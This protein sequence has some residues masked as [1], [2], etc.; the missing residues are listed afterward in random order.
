MNSPRRLIALVRPY[1]PL[2]I[3]AVFLMAVV[4]A[5]E[6]VYALL[7]R[8]IFDQVLKTGYSAAP[9][10]LFRLP[11]HGRAIYLQD[12]LPGHIRDPLTAIVIA[13]V[14]I[15]F[16]KGICAYLGT[17]SV[18]FIGQSVVLNLRNR[19]YNKILRQSVAFFAGNSTGQLMST[20]MNDIERI[21]DAVSH[22]TANFLK[23]SFTLVFL[24]AFI[25]YVDWRLALASLVV[26][27]F[28]VLPSARIGRY[29]RKHSRRSQDRM[30]DLTNILQ[31][32]L[33]GIRVVQAFGMERFEHGKFMAATRRLLKINLR[34]IRAHAL[35]Q[36]LM[37]LL[38]AI[39]IAGSLLYA[40]NEIVHHAQTTGSFVAF[41]Y[42]LIKMYEPI[43]RLTGVNNSFQ[44]AVGASE[45]AFEVL[46]VESEVVQKPNAA[47]LPLFKREIEFDN[48]EFSYSDIPILQG[49]NLKI[50]KGEVVAIVGSSGAGKTT[51]ANLIPRFFDVT[52]GRILFDG[53]DL[54]DVDLSSLRAQIGVVTQETVLFNDT[55]QNNIAYGQN[56]VSLQAAEEAAR[57]ALAHD[58][59]MEMPEGYQTLIGERGQR[60]SGGQRQRIAIA[61]A[62]L[63]DSP[64]LILDE[65]TSS[66]DTESEML[67]QKALTNLIAGRTVLMIAHRL[68]TVRRADRIVVLERGIVTE[69][70]TH[71]DLVTSG[72]LYQRLHELQFV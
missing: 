36:P 41:L 5:C 50:R 27:P 20:V 68:S 46:D 8:P 67:V 71:E 30:A 38:G 29:I 48:V 3:A 63:K 15:T 72:G 69:I 47:P 28:I 70:G 4:G 26:V 43:K 11:F 58:F 59:I 16:I 12:F 66:L 10:F 9:V 24:L 54:R 65:A 42:A 14:G 1:I 53:F 37:E 34:W 7:I 33:T 6:G 17:Y 39:T 61:R 35:T 23:Q 64:I 57:A 44:L 51:L 13:L 31:E 18:N 32:T 60:L 56:S 62:L 19:L 49:V 2:L 52:G 25:F 21:L 45:R 40:R 55:V 22:V